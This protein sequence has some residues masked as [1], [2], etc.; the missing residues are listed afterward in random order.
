MRRPGGYVTITL[1]DDGK[2]AVVTFDGG[3]RR[4]IIR[5]GTFETDTFSCNHCGRVE[6]IPPK[7][8]VNAVGFC[9]NCMLP[10][11]QQ[12]SGKPC[13][14]VEKKLAMAEASYHARRS[15]GF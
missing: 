6:H 7:A 15:Y 3:K 8:D 14:T 11:C 2:N 9:R 13:E 1:P 12:C 5:G 10:I 4:E